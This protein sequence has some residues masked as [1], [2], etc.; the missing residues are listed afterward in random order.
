[1]RIVPDQN[2]EEIVNSLQDTLHAYFKSTKSSN[3]LSVVVENKADWWL[4]DPQ[5]RG[6]KALEKAVAE[7]WGIEPLYIREG[8]SIPGVRWLEKEF[9]AAAVNFP[10]GQASDNAHLVDERLRVLNLERGQKI[11]EKVFTELSA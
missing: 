2:I 4:G 5:N 3:K 9:N 6:F 7:E 10:M 8:G 11:L 1:M